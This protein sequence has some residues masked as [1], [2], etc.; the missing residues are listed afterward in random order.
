MVAGDNLVIYRLFK[1]LNSIDQMLASAFQLPLQL[2]HLLVLLNISSATKTQF[3][4]QLVNLLPTRRISCISW[5]PLIDFTSI[6][7]PAFIHFIFFDKFCLICIIFFILSRF[8]SK[9]VWSVI[10]LIS[11]NC[12]IHFTERYM[13]TII[14]KYFILKNFHVSLSKWYEWQLQYVALFIQT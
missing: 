8:I 9:Y 14:S 12:D 4:A 5:F 2:H 6:L 10:F 11:V 7:S 1:N 13:L 3:Y